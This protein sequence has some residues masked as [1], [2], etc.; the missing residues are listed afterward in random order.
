MHW[1]EIAATDFFTAEV[2][3]PTGLKTYYVLFFIELKTGRVHLAGVTRKPTDLFMGHATEGTLG[4]L[5]GGRF[6]ICD[7]DTKFSARFRIILEAAGIDV[8]QTPHRA[9]N[10]NAYAERFLRSI[11]DECMSR[12]ILFG[13]GHLRRALEQFIEHYHAERNHQGL[14]NELIAGAAT[15]GRGDVICRERLGGLLKF[16]SR[17][18]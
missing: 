15:S 7:R 4:F 2:W 12:M 16:Y 8:V 1:E 11:K 17:A 6:V 3:T 13:E 9:P 14:G 5:R 18:V 10:C